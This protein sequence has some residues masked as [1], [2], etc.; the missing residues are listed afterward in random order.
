[1]KQEG[2]RRTRELPV[3]L[4]GPKPILG[5]NMTAA[6]R[7]E[8]S[9]LLRATAVAERLDE[10]EGALRLIRHELH[11]TTPDLD[12]ALAGLE[13]HLAGLRQLLKV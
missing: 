13:A 2:D 1:V 8:R 12:V 4:R 11:R 7:Q 3:T 10:A 9:R 6:E 5:R